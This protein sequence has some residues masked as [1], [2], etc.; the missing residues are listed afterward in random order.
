MNAFNETKNGK[1]TKKKEKEGEKIKGQ[2]LGGKGKVVLRE[3]DVNGGLSLG[4]GDI[5]AA[6]KSGDNLCRKGERK[7][8]KVGGGKE[9]R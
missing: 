6:G 4:D 8:K 5:N 1:R 9:K 7:K 3:E 2:Y